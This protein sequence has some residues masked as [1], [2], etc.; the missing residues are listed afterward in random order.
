MECKGNLCTVFTGHQH[1]NQNR[2]P[3]EVKSPNP[4][5]PGWLT[6]GTAGKLLEN[7]PPV[8][9]RP[10]SLRGLVGAI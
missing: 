2:L 3:G 7:R 1:E 4:T 9:G 5:G 10:S 8:T 6:N